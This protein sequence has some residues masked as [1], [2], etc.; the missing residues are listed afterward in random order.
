MG[1]QSGSW[2][3]PV[4]PLSIAR[5]IAAL[6]GCEAGESDA[7]VLEPVLGRDFAD[8]RPAKAAAAR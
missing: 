2:D 1:V 4:S 7:E 3:R 6:F 5:T 8:P